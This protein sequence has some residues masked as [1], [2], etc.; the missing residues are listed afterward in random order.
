MRRLTRFGQPSGESQRPPLLETVPRNDLVEGQ[1]KLF[2][3]RKRD[4]DLAAADTRDGE[5][6]KEELQLT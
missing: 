5:L 1:L 4:A 6:V 2:G 3:N